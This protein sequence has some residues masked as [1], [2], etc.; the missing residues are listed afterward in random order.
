MMDWMAIV[1]VLYISFWDSDGSS[2]LKIKI[3]TSKNEK[4]R[5]WLSRTL[6]SS[7]VPT[8]AQGILGTVV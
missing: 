7:P 5:E 8:A 1:C 3:V 4:P 2:E 6:S